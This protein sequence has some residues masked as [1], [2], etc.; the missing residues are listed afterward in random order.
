[1]LHFHVLADDGD[2]GIGICGW[3]LTLLSWMIVLVTLPFSL[4]VCFKVA[5]FII[6]IFICFLHRLFRSTSD[7]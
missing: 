7:R 1:M 3:M 4:C 5:K 6:R 2:D